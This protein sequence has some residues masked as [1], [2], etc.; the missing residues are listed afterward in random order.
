MPT[1]PN[2]TTSPY[3]LIQ[4]GEFQFDQTPENEAALKL[5]IQD[6]S[7]AERFIQAKRWMLEWDRAQLLFEA[8]AEVRYWEG[9]SIPRAHVSVPL[10]LK[11]IESILPQIM[12]GLFSS[13]PPFTFQPRPGTKQDAARAA[14]AVIAYQLDEIGFREEVRKG[15][16]SALLFGNGIWKWGWESSTRKRREYRR[17]AQPLTIPGENGLPPVTIP[18]KQSDRLEVKEI[19]EEV[20]CPTFEFVN[21]RHVLVD[22]GLREPDI[23][24]AK[25][26]IHRMYLTADQLDELRDF[27]GYD[28]PDRETLLN[29]FLPPKEPTH[30]SPLETVP[31]SLEKEFTPLPRWVDSTV[32]PLEQP[33]EV[34]ERWD[35][36]SVITVLN[37]KVV[38]RNEPN[39]FGVIP[40]LSLAYI[41]NI[42]S[43]YGLG[44][45]RLIG[46][47]QRLQQGMINARLD[48][49][50]INLNG[51]FVRQRGKNVPSQNLR[52]RP[53]G[54]IDADEASAITVLPRLNAVPEAYVEVQAS[55]AR[56]ENISAA[57]ELI[58]QG[59][60][61]SEGR[62]SITRTA[63]GVQALTGGS[64]AR[65]QYMVENLA[66][67]V[68]VPFLMQCHEMNAAKL[69]L[70]QLRRILDDELQQAWQGDELD[71]LNARIRF[72]VLAAAKMQV[73]RAMAQSLPLL[74]QFLL[75]APVSQMLQAQGQKIDVAEMVNMLFDVSGWTNH[76]SVVLPLTAEDEQRQAMQNPAVQQAIAA[77][78][79]AQAK[80]AQESSSIEAE[81]MGR[82]G[83]MVIEHLLRHIEQPEL[84]N[85]QMGS[86]QGFGNQA[87]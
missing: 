25:Y 35:N 16:K 79:A 20:A 45:A 31:L 3:E 56:A 32:D 29:L 7:L 73:R 40:F 2:P 57:N 42:D 21:V 49:V 9:T 87:G 52:M 59:S 60:L 27:E 39:E 26:V 43:F 83:R 5:V 69:P 70:P 18:T 28:I 66:D 23:R 84:T 71:I 65:L 54:I 19:E 80:T 72:S 22:P 76:S 10:V 48:E 17:K 74:F 6:T 68:F 77:H 63:T 64:G 75:S 62:S 15:V 8:L 13:D 4:E 51:M 12:S 37:R 38:I 53:G 33:I 14:A 1:L 24:G 82:A 46:G 78:A 36:D 58:V 81:N 61:P 67:Q 50:A 55:D 86:G 44:L 47:E 11:H 41:D 34:L 30:S 85:G